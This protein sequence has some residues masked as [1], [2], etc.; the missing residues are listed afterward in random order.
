VEITFLHLDEVLAIHTDVIN[1]Y[2][3]TQ[4][5]RDLN[6]LKS[7]VSLPKVTFG[8]GYLHSD[9]FDMSAAYLFHI[10]KNHPFLDGNKRTG[11]VAA[12][13]FLEINGV[14]FD[15]TEDELVDVVERTAR[16]EVDKLELAVFLRNHCL[17]P[18]E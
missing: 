10:V 11:T 9:L 1:R 13:V 15:A 4:G 5:I 16:G 8:G 2:G 17:P 6:M 14:R 7:A 12:L 18:A 3:G